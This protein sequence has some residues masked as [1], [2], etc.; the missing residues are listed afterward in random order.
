MK[1]EIKKEKNKSIKLLRNYSNYESKNQK[2]N[3]IF[4][5]EFKLK[6]LNKITK[7]KDSIKIKKNTKNCET[8]Q[9]SRIYQHF[10]LV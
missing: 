1:I 6:K 2:G 10:V 4:K 9:P 3:H 7:K 8:F 5:I